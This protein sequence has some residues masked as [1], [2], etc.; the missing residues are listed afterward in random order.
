MSTYTYTLSNRYV[1]LVVVWLLQFLS[2]F[3]S[4]FFSG[5]SLLAGITELKNHAIFFNAP[6]LE[7][8]V[9]VVNHCG[10][11]RALFS[12]LG[13]WNDIK[14]HPALLVKGLEE[15]ESSLQSSQNDGLW[16]HLKHRRV[17]LA[18]ALNIDGDPNHDLDFEFVSSV[19]NPG[20]EESLFVISDD[21]HAGALFKQVVHRQVLLLFVSLLQ[22]FLI[23]FLFLF[24]STFR[25]VELHTDLLL[26][27]ELVSDGL[28]QLFDLA[29]GLE[30]DN[31]VLTCF[32]NLRTCVN[33]LT[34]FFIS[35]CLLSGNLNLISEGIYDRYFRL[36]LCRLSIFAGLG[37]SGTSSPL[38]R[39]C[40][41]DG[42]VILDTCV[43]NLS[44]ILLEDLTTLNLK[45]DTIYIYV[46]K[47]GRGLLLNKLF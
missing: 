31:S 23:F 3:N 17:V 30:L 1:E 2:F 15:A 27:A 44:S 16:G 28:P 20:S 13:R 33:Y 11:G 26:D 14:L 22:F 12:T 40:N 9:E 8:F 32:L 29:R 21:N 7:G 4:C 39:N 10:S 5:A 24:D 41:N 35:L 19:H 34:S 46:T 25:E 36:I 43:I 47:C 45:L 18:F 38:F 6:F 42:A 37:R